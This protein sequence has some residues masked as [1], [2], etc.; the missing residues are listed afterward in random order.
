M[1][2]IMMVM[3]NTLPQG[4]SIPTPT[5]YL[6]AIDY[7]GSGTTWTAQ[8]GNNATLI[9]TPTFAAPSPTYFSF[10]PASAEKATVPDLG[11]L[12]T[13][14]VE[15]WFRV[16]SSLASSITA[17]VTNEGYAGTNINFTIGQTR[18]TLSRNI[19][20]AFYNGTW[21]T[22][23]GFAPS[24]NTWYHCV[25]TYDGT[26]LRQ[27]VDGVEQSTLS[28]TGTPL[29]GG[30]VRIA[31]RW[32]TQTAPTD[33]FPGD[34]GLTR[35]WNSSLTSSQVSTLYNQNLS[36]FSNSVVTSN[37]V[38]YYDPSLVA[39]YSGS[40]TTINNLTA[41]SLPGTMSNITYTD[42]YFTYNGTNS[43]VS[44]PDNSVLEPGA[45]SWTM[46]VWVNQTNSGNDVVLGKFDPGG[47][48]QDVSYSIRTTG[49]TYYAQLGSGSGSGGGPTGTLYVN[50]TS[51][52]GTPGTWCQLVYVF[53]N[54]ATKTLETY[55]NGSSIG[56]VAHN[57][58]SILNTTSNLYLGSY[59][60]GEYAQ[61][62][63]GKIGITRLYNTALTSS[64]VLQNYNANKGLYGL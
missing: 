57:L 62:F 43:Q 2:G 37:L 4:L 48:S 14:T 21:R 61:W 51:Y 11:N 46:E 44:I 34:I 49:T 25:G 45:G 8:N 28:Y 5:L 47:L 29:S 55:V 32:D 33:F 63:D 35:I 60:N 30:E 39:S 24:L 53:T 1:T 20:A 54:G 9:N 42:P 26:T 15:S 36:R 3:M 56:S 17:V 6:D 13:W 18:A 27:Y 16:T 52:A 7:S 22:T 19:C 64:Q 31:S 23:A 58:A 12:S 50:S 38:A 59:N 10:A 40:G 41:T